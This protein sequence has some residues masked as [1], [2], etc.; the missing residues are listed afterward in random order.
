VSR[1]PRLHVI[2]NDQVLA[3]AG[4]LDTARRILTSGKR[5][6]ALHIR[7]HGTSAAVIHSFARELLDTRQPPSMVFVNDRADVALAVE[8]DGLQLGARSLPVAMVRRWL[9]D[10]RRLPGRGRPVI[11]YS[12]HSAVE[13]KAAIRDG[14]DLVLA[15]TIWPS[16]THPGSRPAGPAL[17][18][19][20][21]RG[22]TRPVLAIGGVRPDRVAA[23]CN[24]GAWGVAVLGHVWNGS[25]PEDPQRACAELLDALDQADPTTDLD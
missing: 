13:A 4:F 11:G 21:A 18:E 16:A 17:I 9:D 5:A 10:R 6:I 19:A 25:W 12:A 3:R 22:S 1:V 15:G 20:T 23:A 8:A 7:G 14:A 24:A 2:T